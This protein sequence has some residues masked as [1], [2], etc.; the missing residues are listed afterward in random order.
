MKYISAAE[1][2]A[3]WNLSTHCVGV[4]CYEGRIEGAQKADATRI[5]HETAENPA[6]ARIKSGKHIKQNPNEIENS[7]CRK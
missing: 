3:K 5:I 6:D 1:V 2:A 7:W 4:L